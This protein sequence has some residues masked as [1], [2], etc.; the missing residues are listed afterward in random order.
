MTTTAQNPLEVMDTSTHDAIVDQ[1]RACQTS[2]EILNFEEWFNS[3]SNGILLYTVIL[4][5]L[6]NRSISRATASKWFEV[7][8]KDRDQQI[9]SLRI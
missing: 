6:K 7:L 5:L 3:K 4:D 1:L 8:L 2:E 9:D